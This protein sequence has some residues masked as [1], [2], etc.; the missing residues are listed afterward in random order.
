MTEEERLAFIEFLNDE[1]HEIEVQ[2]WL[3]GERIGRDP[4]NEYV[5]RWIEDNADDYRKRWLDQHRVP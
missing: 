1:K 5:L 4:G 3:E 2:K